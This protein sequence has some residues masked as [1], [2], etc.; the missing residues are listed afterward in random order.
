MHDH[1]NLPVRLKWI[2]LAAITAWIGSGIVFQSPN[3]G[4]VDPVEAA[5]P[6]NIAETNLELVHTEDGPLDMI[7]CLQNCWFAGPSAAKLIL[8]Q[9]TTDEDDRYHFGLLGQYGNEWYRT[10]EQSLDLT[11]PTKNE[12]PFTLMARTYREGESWMYRWGIV[13]DYTVTVG[14]ADPERLARVDL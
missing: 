2:L 11:D 9:D 13:Q 5:K 10:G 3:H 4:D 8:Y 1:M 12:Q 6:R 14:R 7:G